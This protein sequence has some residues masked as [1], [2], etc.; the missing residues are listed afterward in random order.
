[1]IAPIIYPK[2]GWSEGVPADNGL[3]GV[4]LF[5]EAFFGYSDC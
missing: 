3:T 5:S 2:P 1:M 4:D